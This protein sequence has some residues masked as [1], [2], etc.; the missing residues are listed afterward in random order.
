MKPLLA[1]LVVTLLSLFSAFPTSQASTPQYPAWL[2]M[3]PGYAEAC[4]NGGGCIP[5]TQAELQ[6]LAA[7]VMQRAM[8]SCRR[9]MTI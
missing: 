4:I 2:E 5:M 6:D 1:I 3:K 9:G 7:Q 8:Q